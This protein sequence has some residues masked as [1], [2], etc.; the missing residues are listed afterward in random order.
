MKINQ[1]TVISIN[2]HTFFV[3]TGL[4]ECLGKIYYNIF[5]NLITMSSTHSELQKKKK[6][7]RVRNNFINILLNVIIFDLYCIEELLF[8]LHKSVHWGFQ[9]Y[10][11]PNSSSFCMLA[12]HFGIN[13]IDTAKTLSTGASL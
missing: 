4:D 5:S 9:Y 7:K 12:R 10:S 1:I 6:K 8:L 2:S 13:F 11:T 3:G